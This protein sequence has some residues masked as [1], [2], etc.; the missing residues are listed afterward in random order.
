MVSCMVAPQR[1]VGR[2]GYHWH[3]GPGSD[4]VIVIASQGGMPRHPVWYLDLQANPEA[5][6]QVG[7]EVRK[8]RA[9][10]LEGEEKEAC[11]RRAQE[12]YPDFDDYQKRTD[13]EI[14]LL[15]LEPR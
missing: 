6:Y 12:I 15:V 3:R 11:W 10:E 7:A 1:S 14:P 2:P 5:E 9:R 4:N 13:R 8:Y